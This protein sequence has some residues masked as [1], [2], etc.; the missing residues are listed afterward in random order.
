MFLIDLK[1][2]RTPLHAAC[3]GGNHD[4][5]ELLLSHGADVNIHDDVSNLVTFFKKNVIPKHDFSPIEFI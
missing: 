1:M 3:S 5:V 4:C 2:G